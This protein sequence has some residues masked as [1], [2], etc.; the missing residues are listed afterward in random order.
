MK[1]L[2]R[3]EQLIED[4][5]DLG[6]LFE[7]TQAWDEALGDLAKR[8]ETAPRLK[9]TLA[10]GKASFLHTMQWYEETAVLAERLYNYAFCSMPAMLRTTTMSEFACLPASEPALRSLGFL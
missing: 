5:W 1:T 7:N 3:S 2:S 9:G 10:A 6:S 4:T 8:I